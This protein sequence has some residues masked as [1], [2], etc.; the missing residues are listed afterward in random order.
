MVAGVKALD[1]VESENYGQSI[2]SMYCKRVGIQG[3][4]VNT[5]L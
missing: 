1:K 5:A 2:L 3:R 4:Q